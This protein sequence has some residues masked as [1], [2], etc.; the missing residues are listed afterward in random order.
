MVFFL[1][2]SN[3]R[4]LISLFKRKTRNVDVLLHVI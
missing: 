3:E 4:Y 1:F 2:Q